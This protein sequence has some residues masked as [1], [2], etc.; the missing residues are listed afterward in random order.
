MPKVMVEWTS[1]KYQ[2]R[3]LRAASRSPCL[4]ARHERWSKLGRARY[5]E[6]QDRLPFEETSKPPEP[7][8]AAPE[9]VPEPAPAP[10]PTAA[11]SDDD[12]SE[13]A[14]DEAPSRTEIRRMTKAELATYIIQ[15][16]GNADEEQ[17]TREVL[18]ERALEI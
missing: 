11:R 3:M 17:E 8:A 18:L 2:T 7:T 6:T 4:R 12:D 16:G 15:H 9:P 13:F 5:V 10:Q 14:D 1:P